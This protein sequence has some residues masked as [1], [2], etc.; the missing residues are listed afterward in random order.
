MRFWFISFFRLSLYGLVLLV[1]GIGISYIGKKIYFVF[2]LG[3]VGWK[4]RNVLNVRVESY[5]VMIENCLRYC[6]YYC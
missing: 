2:F 6:F 1:I 3:M 5:N 4:E